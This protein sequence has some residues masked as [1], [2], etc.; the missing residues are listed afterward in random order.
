MRAKRRLPLLPQSFLLLPQSFLLPLLL[1]QQAL[2][3]LLHGVLEIAL[4]FLQIER[5]VWA[6]LVVHCRGT[7]A[8]RAYRHADSPTREDVTPPAMAQIM[9]LGGGRLPILHMVGIPSDIAD[10]PKPEARSSAKPGPSSRP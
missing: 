4:C 10:T 5:A 7:L 1:G 3:R 6:D 9:M 8:V 2:A